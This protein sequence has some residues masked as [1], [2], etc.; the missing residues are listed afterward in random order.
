M[1]TRQNQRRPLAFQ[2]RRQKKYR[3]RSTPEKKFDDKRL[4]K[5]R[6]TIGVEIRLRKKQ[7]GLAALF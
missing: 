3:D 4:E 1:K 2:T 7:G 5:Y 6:K